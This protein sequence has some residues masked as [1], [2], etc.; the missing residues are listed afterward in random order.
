MAVRRDNV[1]SPAKPSALRLQ[2]G[3]VVCG[4]LLWLMADVWTRD[5]KMNSLLMEQQKNSQM[6]EQTENNDD[7]RDAYVVSSY[8]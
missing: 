4:D 2:R 7:E 6:P 3:N 5:G 1:T 8:S